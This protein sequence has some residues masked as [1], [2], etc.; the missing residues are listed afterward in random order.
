MRN[1]QI[2]G[3]VVALVLGGLIGHLGYLLI[4]TSADNI[5]APIMGIAGI[6]ALALGVFLVEAFDRR[7]RGE[8]Q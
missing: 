1:L 2:L 7:E 5:G 8:H 3:L 6:M 4:S